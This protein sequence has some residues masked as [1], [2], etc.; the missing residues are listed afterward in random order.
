MCTL[1]LAFPFSP[2]WRVVGC[3]VSVG[4]AT[5]YAGRFDL[6]VHSRE[7][8]GVR[9]PLVGLVRWNIVC[10]R[11]SRDS[12]TLVQLHERRG[13]VCWL[14]VFLKKRRRW[15]DPEVRQGWA[16]RWR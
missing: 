12:R 13:S 9:A 11:V 10:E 14:L 3:F 6:V 2:G 7:M 15:T 4:K 8:G 1:G 16:R 5:A